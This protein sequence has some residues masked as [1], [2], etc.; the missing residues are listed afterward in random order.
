MKIKSQQFNPNY[1]N[2]NNN[3]TFD[4]NYSSSKIQNITLKNQVNKIIHAYRKYKNK[5]TMT[6]YS[7]DFLT[8]YNNP[9]DREEYIGGRDEQ[10]NKSGFG[11][12][13]MPEGNI[14]KGYFL[15]DKAHGWG[16]Y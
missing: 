3:L 14:F 4:N 8:S 16:I 10:G 7:N 2:S 13:R 5:L 9:Q 12:Q 6:Q 11:I 1:K 15:N